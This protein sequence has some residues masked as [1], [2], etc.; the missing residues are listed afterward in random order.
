MFGSM[1]RPRHWFL[2]DLDHT[3][4][5]PEGAN[6]TIKQMEDEGEPVGNM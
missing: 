2:I 6:Y 3:I 4:E 5:C 1:P